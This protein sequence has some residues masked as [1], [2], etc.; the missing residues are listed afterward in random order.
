MQR[1]EDI[2]SILREK[3]VNDSSFEFTRLYRNLFNKDFYLNAYIKIYAEE[4]K[5]SSGINHLIT[6]FNLEQIAEIIELLKNESYYPTSVVG[7]NILQKESKTK[8]S[9]IQTVGDK[10]IQEV[11]RQILEVIYEP[12]FLNSSHGFRPQRSSHTAL[13]QIKS[14]CNGANWVIAGDINDF[15]KNID[16]HILIKLLSKKIKDGRF[17]ELINRFLNSGC[18]AFKPTNHTVSGARGGD[19]L[20]P[21][22]ANIYLHE[23]DKFMAK[24]ARIYSVSSFKKIN[25]ISQHLNLARYK[26]IK[27]GDYHRAYELLLEMRKSP[28][29]IWKEPNF[30]IKYTRYAAAFVVSIRGNKELARVIRQK[31]SW[32]LK[33]NLQLELNLEQTQIT[34]LGDTRVR[35]LDYEIAKTPANMARSEPKGGIKNCFINETV[36]LLVPSDV[37]RDKLKPF[38][39]DGKSIHHGARVNLPILDILRQFNSEIRGLYNYYALA[40]DVSAKI[41]KFKYYHYASLAKTI[42]RKEKCSVK[43]V[44]DK[45]GVEVQLKQG[46][47]TR[48]IISVTYETPAGVR[49]LTYFNESLSKI[50]DNS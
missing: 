34:N 47:G 16:Y 5:L 26:A 9:G 23:L 14:S 2:L 10:L 37:V 17:L 35:F 18:L 21:L 30:K 4:G 11:L 43:K 48:K 44:I 20:G 6:D 40:T 36:Q 28:S 29:Q 46:T 8:P 25:P 19:I 1:A 33:A 22:L 27:N 15:L 12:I 7:K 41:G 50:N 38:M 49:L 13:A 24:I 45:Y 42:A 31:I 32:F 3:S 39:K